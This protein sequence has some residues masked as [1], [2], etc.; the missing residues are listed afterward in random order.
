MKTSFFL[1]RRWLRPDPKSR[2]PV[3]R[4]TVFIAL[5]RNASNTTDFF[6]I[7]T[8]RVIEIGSQVAI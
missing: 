4:Q 6:A 8:D 3:W 7:A 5:A 2:M 1:S